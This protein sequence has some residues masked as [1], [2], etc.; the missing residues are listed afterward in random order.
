MLIGGYFEKKLVK[1][2][3]MKAHIKFYPNVL[4]K[5]QDIKFYCFSIKIT[6]GGG[7]TDGHIF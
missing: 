1:H 4:I 7:V 2:I 3:H 6:L 5:K